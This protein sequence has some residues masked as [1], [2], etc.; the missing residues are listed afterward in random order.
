VKDR[1]MLDIWSRDF[2]RDV[3][4]RIMVLKSEV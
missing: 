4:G 2:F 1:K 3:A